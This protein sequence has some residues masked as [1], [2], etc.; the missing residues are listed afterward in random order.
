MTNASQPAPVW[1]HLRE[2]LRGHRL[3]GTVDHRIGEVLDEYLGHL[4]RCVAAGEVTLAEG[5]V[6]GNAAVAAAGRLRP[7]PEARRVPR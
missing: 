2:C 4:A 3:A 6:V 7:L 1:T 5:L